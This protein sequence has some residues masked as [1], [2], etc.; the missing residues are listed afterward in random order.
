MSAIRFSHKAM[1]GWMVLLLLGAFF[2]VEEAAGKTAEEKEAGLPFS[3]DSWSFYPSMVVTA[4]GYTS[5]RESTGKDR[6]HPAFGLTR[7]GVQAQRGVLSTVAADPRVFP[8]GTLLYIPGYGYGVV[9]D[10]GNAIQGRRLDLYFDTV[11]EVYKQWGKKRV[12][13]YVIAKGD[14]SLSEK[15]LENLNETV[16]LTGRQPESPD[17]TGDCQDRKVRND[18]DTTDGPSVQCP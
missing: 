2:P 15:D 7:S 12:R 3:G 16:R 1:R 6:S 17:F 5:G 18:P 14:G 13:I 10:T 9:A 8:I 11:E 4:T